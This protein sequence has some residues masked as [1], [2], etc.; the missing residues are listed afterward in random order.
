MNI[1][2]CTN[3]SD[4]NLSFTYNVRNEK[5][6][7]SFAQAVRKVC[8]LRACGTCRRSAISVDTARCVI[9]TISFMLSEKRHIGKVN[10]TNA[11]IIKRE[12]KFF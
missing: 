12:G 10:A 1:I 5:L 8:E 6:A 9:R 7:M 4:T 3:N 2:I 11:S